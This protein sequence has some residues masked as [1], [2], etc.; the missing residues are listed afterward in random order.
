MFRALRRC[1]ALTLTLLLAV[2]GLGGTWLSVAHPCPVDTPWLNQEGHAAHQAHGAGGG[3]DAPAESSTTCHC[4]GTCQNA[5]AALSSIAAAP[6]FTPV[7]T[8]WNTA[9]S[10]PD[11]DTPA[12]PRLRRHPPSTAP[13]LA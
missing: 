13:P 5:S 6:A 7:L 10:S 8:G 9:P 11:R 3:H 12:Q 2:P 1:H 4:V